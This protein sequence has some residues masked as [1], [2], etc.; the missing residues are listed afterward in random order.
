MTFIKKIK[1]LA[2]ENDKK[3]GKDAI[4]KIE[5]LLLNNIEIIIKKASRNADFSGRK[6]IKPEDIETI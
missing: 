3:I 4:K 1:I 6:V 5:S 2:K